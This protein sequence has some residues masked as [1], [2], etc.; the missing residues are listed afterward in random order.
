M[1]AF[2]MA[3]AET[4]SYRFDST[5]LPKAL[6]KILGDHPDLD[7]NFIYNELENYKTS[8]IVKTDNPY[9]ALRQ[10]IGLN[11][12]SVVK[13]RDSYYI[14][15]LQHGKYLYRGKV[16]GKD[17]EPVVAATVMLLAP[18]DSTVITY[19][20]TD[21]AGRFNI[22]CDRQK[23]IAKISCIGYRTVH[24]LC[25]KFDIG[26]ITMP[27]R[28]IRLRTLNVEA[29]EAHLYPD[30]SVYI[31]T[32][33]QKNASQTGAD[34]LGHMAIP[35]L[36][37]LSGGNVVTAAGKPVAV[38]IDYL[39][40]TENDLSAMR[41][42][43]VK[44]VEYYVYPSDP[45]LQ[46][47]PYVI[48]FVMQ[49]YEYGGY[50]KTLGHANLISNPI[51]EL[52]A[53]LRFQRNKMTY[54][55][56]GATYHY[57]RKHEG[58]ELTETYRLP[59]ESG[60]IKEFQRVSNTN[61]S[62]RKY[63]WYFATLK[64]TYNSD[65]VQASS[66]VKGSIDRQPES[67]K[68]G[69][70]IYN[71]PIFN[72]SEYIS[73]AN[74]RSQFIAYEG[75]YFFKLKNNNS[76]VVS[77]TYS[78]S[79]TQQNSFY[80]ETGFAD[81]INGATDNTNKFS[82]NLKFT[83]NFGNYGNLFVGIK[84]L[85][86]YNRTYYAGFA[87]GPDRAKSSRIEAEAGYDVSI[88]KFYGSASFA[89]DWDRL[90]FGDMIDNPSTPKASLSLQYAPNDN[91]SI[92]ISAS[93]ESWLPSPSYKSDKVIESTP[94]IKYTGNP[95]L[96][97]SKSYDFDF[98]YTWIPN[99]NFS[100]SAFAWAW[101]V[102]DRYVYDYEATSTGVVRT[103]KQPMGSFAQGSYGV[104]GSA[105]FLNR[106][107]V[108]SGRICQL[109]NHNGIPYNVNHSYINWYARV[110][111]YLGNWN[112]TLTYSSDNAVA[113]GFMN[114]LWSYGKSDWYITIG[115]SNSRWNIRGDIINFT[116][117]NYRND[118]L[119]M[120]SKYYDT[121]EIRLGGNSRAFIQ[122]LATYTFG[123]GKKV[124]RDDEPSIS[125]SASSG[126]LK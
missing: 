61:A 64:A 66:L 41:T 112:F 91:N 100:L 106:S 110:R 124:K 73:R 116:R 69:S 118:H 4:F 40:A 50:V 96:V 24:L 30:R 94:L 122:L 67:E 90:Q 26:T 27:E 99:N 34:L 68:I 52:R 16:I 55:I 23:V 18:R 92:D 89:W 126:I 113:D 84:G 38:F 76:I 48:N 103:I 39:P 123:Y 44:K 3:E 77:P 88:G 9:D 46:G 49:K 62:V 42:E 121:D 10:T 105:R 107:L 102:G 95:N 14:E 80:K 58:S 5:P 104:N 31:P 101:F 87:S 7:V 25:N 53:N 21:E 81:I 36:G 22:P 97:P 65:N 11:P 8:A 45:R 75:N 117:W 35:Q 72:N 43:D 63:N 111:Y 54:D 71:T 115:W 33:R 13:F 98:N 57:D 70:V 28:A 29:D 37:L 17:K 59:Q 6:M 15:A 1:S 19:G 78:Y 86:E 125:G 56:M 119:I 85:Y 114:G 51:G 2:F 109:L 82:V 120:K 32:A 108:F 79:H 74:E 93:Y 83:H 20:I 12:V 47:K 60:E